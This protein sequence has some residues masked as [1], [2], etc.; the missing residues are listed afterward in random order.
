MSY[1]FDQLKKIKYKKVSNGS[2][3][4]TAELFKKIIKPQFE[5]ISAINEIHRSIIDYVNRESPTYFIRLYGQF[6]PEKYKLQR[7]GFLT[8]YPDKT[9]TVFCDNT[10][11]L[12]FTGMK[13]AGLSFTDIQLKNFLNQKQL[14]VGFGQVSDEKELAYYDPKGAIRF[15]L[16]GWYQAH[17]YPVGKGFYGKGLMKYFPNPERNEYNLKNKKRFL[18]QNLSMDELKV[19]KAHFLRLIHPFN[20]F[21]IPNQKHIQYDGKN[22]GE[23]ADVI[24]Y[25]KSKIHELFPQQYQEFESYVNLEYQFPKP[26]KI[27]EKIKWFTES[28]NNPPKKVNNNQKQIK[29]NSKK[30]SQDGMKIGAFVRDSFR[31]AYKQNLITEDEIK[32]LLKESSKETFNLRYTILA[33]D[34]NKYDAKRYYA[35]EFCGKYKLT[36]DWYDDNRNHWQHF[37]NWLKKIGY[38]YKE[39]ISE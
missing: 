8:E 11:T 15:N 31:K 12:L 27:I 9:K 39:K 28:K 33:L 32:R 3:S 13:L 21:L 2:V 35:G 24:N 30:R 26:K 37:L 22:I 17:I 34:D 38:S 18:S 16:K 36:N 19:L 14:I 20:S 7:R 5:N 4:N 10:F 23:E 1:P 25:V 6:K 29:A